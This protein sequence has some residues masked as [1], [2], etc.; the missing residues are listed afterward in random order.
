[1]QNHDVSNGSPTKRK[2]ADDE[3]DDYRPVS[4]L[5]QEHDLPRVP[6]KLDPR[7]MTLEDPPPHSTL[8][9][10]KHTRGPELRRQYIQNSNPI[11]IAGETS[12]SRLQRIISGSQ[13]PSKP[14]TRLPAAMNPTKISEKILYPSLSTNRT[15]QASVAA[16]SDTYEYYGYDDTFIIDPPHSLGLHSRSKD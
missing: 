12:T 16:A 15:Q 9:T 1:M 8:H 4:S 11:R 2:R 3:G 14:V 7:H 10:Y 5:V 13:T 6:P